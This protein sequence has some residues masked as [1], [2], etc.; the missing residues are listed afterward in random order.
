MQTPVRNLV[1]HNAKWIIGCKVVQSVMQLVIGMICARYLGP[2]N[3]GLIRYAASIVAF[4][5]PLMRLGLDATLV[6]ELVENPEKEQSIMGTALMLNVASGLV[7]MGL[8]YGFV[9]A[10]HPGEQITI[11]V[12]VIY[13]GSLLFSALEMV[14]YWFQY[15]LMSK[16][17]SLVMLGAYA[18]VSAYKIFLLASGKSV[19]WF[20]FA[21]SVEYGTVAAGLTAIYLS[22]GRR[23]ELDFS[24]VGKM[25][26]KSRHYILASMMVVVIQ[27]TDHIM[28]T[29]MLGQWENGIYSA[30][31]TC[32]TAAQFVYYA[33]IDSF[34]PV[35]FARKGENRAA[36]ERGISRLYCITVYLALGQGI[37][38]TVFAKPLVLLLY[39][40]D[41][42][43]AAGLMGILSAYFLFSTIG[44]VRN[45]WILAEGRNRWLWV[46]NLS[47]A[48]MNVALNRVMIPAWGAWGAAAASMLTQFFANVVM[49][50]LIR[51]M[52]G[53]NRLLLQGISPGFVMQEW[54]LLRKRQNDEGDTYE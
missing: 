19:Y 17:A 51:P 35:L 45:I 21:H 30:A 43:D 20:A 14:R 49:G 25:L 10:V 46:I 27:N 36:Y 38:F 48:V 3:Y 7:C 33:V 29:G 16:Y 47:G 15:K 42:V 24:M 50:Y 53:N 44:V 18:V 2:D 13:S 4:G 40:R 34:R 22:T 12:C 31:I 8:V 1:F 11:L 52:R 6:H 41:Y 9:S 37:V 32:T 23:F 54:K 39:G 26:R 28:L 5:V